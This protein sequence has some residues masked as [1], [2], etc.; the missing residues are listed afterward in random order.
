MTPGSL[1]NYY[2]DE[3]NDDTNENNDT[4]N[5]RVNNNK[6]TKSKSF[7]Y[8]TKITESTPASTRRLDS[9]R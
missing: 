1:L 7:E 9:S 4:V 5:H 6:T 3:V 8:K 2:T